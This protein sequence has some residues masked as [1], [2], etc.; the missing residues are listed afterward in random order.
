MFTFTSP[1][2]YQS[3]ALTVSGS[4]VLQSFCFLQVFAIDIF[5]IC[6]INLNKFFLIPL[7]GDLY[8]LLF[9]KK[10]DNLILY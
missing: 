6:K 9:Y 5:I 8:S 3:H 2:L 7:S 1:T 10:W 4:A